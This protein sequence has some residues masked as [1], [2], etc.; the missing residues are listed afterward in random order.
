MPPC[1]GGW[2]WH[3]PMDSFFYGF[4]AVRIEVAGRYSAATIFAADACSS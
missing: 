2:E 3:F 1:A 4:F